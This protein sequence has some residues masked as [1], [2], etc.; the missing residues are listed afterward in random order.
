MLRTVV[1]PALAVV[2]VSTGM[3]A[4]TAAPDTEISSA[5]AFIALM[6]AEDFSAATAR[7]DPTMK[8]AL[9]ADR[10]ASTWARVLA[11]A[12]P[13]A[14]IVSARQEARGPFKV[15]STTCRFQNLN[16]DVVTTFNAA[17]EIAGLSFPPQSIQRTAAPATAWSWPAYANA[18]TFTES[19]ITIGAGTEWPLPGTLTM[20]SGTGP[21]PVV[22]LVHGS[23][24]GDRDE[25]VGPNKPF[26]DLA[27]GL[28][29]RG[30]A[31]IRY[32]KRSHTH[33]PKV[34]ALARLTVKDEVIDDVV[35]AVAVARALPRVAPSRV[36]VLGHSFGGTLVPRIAAVA[37]GV[38][39]FVVMAGATRPIEQALVEQTRYIAKLDGRIAPDEQD[40]IDA[41]QKTADTIRALTSADAEGGVRVLNVPA[42][43]WLDLRGYQPAIAALS[44]ARPLLVM[45]GE[46]DYQVTAGEF[47]AWK[48]ALAATPDV[49]FKSYT[50]LN[51]L[52]IT[53]SGPS[54]PDEY[55]Q[56]GHV[57]EPVVEDIAG[58]I[59]QH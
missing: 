27:G 5:R 10:L 50:A 42:S 58:W 18:A 59:R 4:Q 2:L 25:T 17:G 13:Y 43:Y 6:A 22:I 31:V 33:G 32:D 36:F 37:P 15:V 34:A 30:V 51:H 47:A 49:T 56:P 1:I 19:D 44:V 40:A 45:Q 46:R 39:G 28:A 20:P 26:R 54:G 16:L 35:S 55:F 24:P 53:G 48:T 11:Q 14:G 29:S 9:P 12:G 41:L 3:L 8:A 52:F 21:F 38:R 7:F 57:A 23:G